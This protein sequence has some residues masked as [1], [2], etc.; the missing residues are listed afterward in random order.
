MV[1]GQDPEMLQNRRLGIPKTRYSV[2]TE[3]WVAR[4]TFEPS[5]QWFWA[6]N[7]KLLKTAFWRFQK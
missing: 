7:Q 3:K 5:W 1:W 4:H 2:Q 6:R